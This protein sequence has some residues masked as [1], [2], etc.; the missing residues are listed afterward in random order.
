VKHLDTYQV[1]ARDFLL[2]ESFRGLFDAPGVGKTGPSIAAGKA[3]SQETGAPVLVTAPAYLLA[4]WKSEIEAFFPGTRVSVANGS[5]ADS[6]RGAITDPGA[7][8]VLTSYNNWSAKSRGSYQYPELHTTQWAALIYDE[9]HRLR[10][11]N[12]VSTRHVYELRKRS[13]GNR[14]TPIWGLTGTPIV[15]NPGDLYPL[16]KLWRSSEYR[17]YWKFVEAWCD[18]ERTPWA[19]E[20]GQLKRGLEDE[21]QELLGSFALRRT[22]RDVPS[23]AGLEELHHSY[24]VDMPA[25]VRKTIAKAKKEYRI[26]H[27]DLASTQFVAGGGSLYPKLRMLA[28]SPPTKEKPKIDFLRDFSEDHHG[29]LVVFCWYKSS[30]QAVRE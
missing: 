7:E 24:E 6:R 8:F 15:N 26:E 9:V 10:G 3:R 11:R 19:T 25:S 20:V 23:L 28:T 27:P 30:A 5:G 21:F 2:K 4:N 18:I 17:S 22:L 13:S 14:D 1:E 29:P 12:S 16:F